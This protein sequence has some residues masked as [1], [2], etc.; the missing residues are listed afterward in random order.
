MDTENLTEG[1]QIKW[2]LQAYVYQALQ[3]K[4]H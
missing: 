1:G 4:Q 2:A 3:T